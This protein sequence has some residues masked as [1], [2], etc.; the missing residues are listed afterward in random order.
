MIE[1]TMPFGGHSGR[2]VAQLP[3][4]YMEWLLDSGPRLS[5]SL[6]QAIRNELAARGRPRPPEPEAPPERVVCKS[7]NSDSMHVYWQTMRDGRRMVRADCRVCGA[8]CKYLSQTPAHVALADK[9][10]A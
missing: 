4:G 2:V 3:A 10:R 7:C 1:P 6:E 8:F 5:H 9:G